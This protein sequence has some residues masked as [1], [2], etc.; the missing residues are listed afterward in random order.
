MPTW[1][2]HPWQEEARGSESKQGPGDTG[3]R[4][5]AGGAARGAAARGAARGAESS[6]SPTT[7]SPGGG[8]RGRRAARGAGP[9]MGSPALYL[10]LDVG[11]Q[12][13]KAGLWEVEAGSEAHPVSLGRSEL[14]VQ[15][16]REGAAEQDPDAWLAAARAAVRSALRHAG[17]RGAQ[18]VAAVGVSGQQHG[19]VAVDADGRP[20]R[21]CKL[22]CDTESHAEAAMLSAKLGTTFGPAFTASKLLWLARHEPDAWSRTTSFL[23]P[24]DYVNLYLTGRRCTECSDASGTGLLD[25]ANRRWLSPSQLE[26]LLPG[27]TDR[28]PDLLGPDEAVGH[29]RAEVAQ[30]W[31][32]GEG[33]VLVS[34]GGGDN[35]MAALGAGCVREGQAVISLGT[36]GTLFCCSPRPVLDPVSAINNFCDATGFWLPLLCTMNC[37]APV[38]EVKQ[39][40]S[41]AGSSDNDGL[42]EEQAMHVPP[43]CD[44]VN[45]LP[46]LGGERTPDWPHAS[47]SLLGLRPGQLQRLPLIYRAAMEGASFALKNAYERSANQ[48]HFPPFKELRAVGGGSNSGLWCQILAD[49]FGVPVVK[50]EEH[51]NLETE[52]AARG[53]AVQ[54]AAVAAGMPVGE[55]VRGI[56]VAIK[57]EKWEPQACNAAKYSEAYLRHRRLGE[58]LFAESRPV[59]GSGE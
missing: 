39:L 17:P 52:A 31:G 26:D 18:R 28:L 32:L 4:P 50:I 20:V 59:S 30:E 51:E 12:S 14:D 56:Q 49:T 41:E 57:P 9:V 22:W 42:L 25:V 45:F 3:A 55:F 44:G 35:A 10:G 47:G 48:E 36:S 34:P 53:A 16:P 6:G 1:R 5:A 2:L 46:Y 33:C 24:K 40:W 54:A 11:T 21:P 7:G 8:G 27:L 58:R 43:G 19:L 15:R 37:T 29:L 23:L 38:Q 13:V